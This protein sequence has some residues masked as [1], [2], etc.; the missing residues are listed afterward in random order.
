MRKAEI[1]NKNKMQTKDKTK[2]FFFKVLPHPLGL[3][4]PDYKQP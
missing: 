4:N 3:V 2:L 1:H